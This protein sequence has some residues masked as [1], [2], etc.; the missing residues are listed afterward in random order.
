MEFRLGYHDQIRVVN[1]FHEDR[2][3]Y[4]TYMT[5]ADEEDSSVYPQ[6]RVRLNGVPSVVIDPYHE[7]SEAEHV[8]RTSAVG[9]IPPGESVLQLDPMETSQL[10]FRLVG[11]S[12][13][14]KESSHLSVD[15][16][17]ESEPAHAEQGGWN[18][19]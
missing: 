19:W 17:L 16:T 12:L 4:L 18:V 5:A 15:F 9:M 6:T 2:M 8:A 10:N 1:P 11:A 14:S 3:L 7:G 13:L